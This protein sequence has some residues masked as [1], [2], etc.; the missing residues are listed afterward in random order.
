MLEFATNY[1]YIILGLQAICAIH[2]IRKGTQNKWIWLIVFLP[3]VGSIAYI[4]TEIFT[5]REMEQVQSGAGAIFNPSGKIKKL[6]DNLRFRDTFDNRI[7]LA[8][9]Y[10]AAGQFDS[11]IELYEKSLVGAFSEHGHCSMQ[12]IIA[13]FE[14]KRYDD[15]IT[16][17]KKIYRLPQFTRSR[18]HMLYAIALGYTSQNEEAEKEFSFMKGKFSNYECRYYYGRFLKRANRINEAKQVFSEMLNESSHLSSNEKR[19]SRE[20]LAK[21]KEEVKSLATA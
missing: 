20:W 9:A 15:L 10:L 1:Y 12:L 18:P 8:D 5:R 11:A 7:A 21:A 4:F 19:I 3:L 16:I 17:A 14:K 13:Y 6:Q 2:C